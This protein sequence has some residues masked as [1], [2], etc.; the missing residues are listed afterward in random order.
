MV[1]RRSLGSG[2]TAVLGV[3]PSVSGGRLHH[4]HRAPGSTEQKTA[5]LELKLMSDGEIRLGALHLLQRTLGGKNSVLPLF[6]L[7]HQ[8]TFSTIKKKKKIPAVN[9]YSVR[10]KKSVT[11][12]RI[13]S[14]SQSLLSLSI[15]TLAVCLCVCLCAYLSVSFNP[16]ASSPRHGCISIT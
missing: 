15:R 3:T 1:R 13:L 6:V 8:V 9:S 7:G 16:H 11:L 5:G 2:C 14:F 10:S 12:A 4:Q